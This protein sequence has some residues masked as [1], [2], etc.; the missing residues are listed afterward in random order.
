MQPLFRLEM[1]KPGSSFAI[2]IA[3]KI[4]L[5]EEILK[6]AAEKVGED[7]IN[8]DRHLREIIRDKRYWES[9]R[10]QIRIAEKELSG[11]VN[12][13]S[14]ELE[15]VQ[16]LKKEILRK[17]QEEAEELLSKANSEIENTIRTIRESQADKEKTKG[18]RESLQP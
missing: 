2:D 18:A 17:A 8:F 1:G 9:K 10:D 15:Q 6:N 12:K 4:G 7:H 16:K 11:V 14:E 5:P 13:Y 3:R